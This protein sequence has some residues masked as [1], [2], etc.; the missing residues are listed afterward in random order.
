L[1]KQ[2][3]FI[4]VSTCLS[5]H[6]QARTHAYVHTCHRLHTSVGSHSKLGSVSLML[7][8]VKHRLGKCALTQTGLWKLRC[9][10]CTSFW[11]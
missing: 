11:Y 5:K 8:K 9:L 4:T 6:K 2:L 7:A 1:Y 3:R 10:N